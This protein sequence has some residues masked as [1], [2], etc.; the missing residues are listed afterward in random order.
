MHLDNPSLQRGHF[1]INKTRK[2]LHKINMSTT[3]LC[4]GCDM[5]MEFH[6]DTMGYCKIF[7]HFLNDDGCDINGKRWI[8]INACIKKFGIKKV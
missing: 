5:L 7:K 6:E 3:K 4:N 8:R 1:V 2:I